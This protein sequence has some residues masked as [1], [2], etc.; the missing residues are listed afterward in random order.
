MDFVFL[1]IYIY[2]ES[3]IL[4]SQELLGCLLKSEWVL[5]IM[6]IYSAAHVDHVYENP[7]KKT[8]EQT[9]SCIV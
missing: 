6:Y 1:Y 5:I 3:Q 8:N 7:Q 4:R 9:N 2:L